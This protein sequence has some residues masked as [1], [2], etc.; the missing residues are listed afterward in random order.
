MWMYSDIM[1]QVYV[2]QTLELQVQVMWAQAANPRYATACA[3][4]I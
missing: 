2:Q 3:Y 1:L 4:A